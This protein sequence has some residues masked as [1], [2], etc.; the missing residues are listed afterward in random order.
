MAIMREAS[1]ADMTTYIKTKK[2][3]NYISITERPN[4]QSELWN[5]KNE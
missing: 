2:W 3:Y 5:Y 1:L 4:G